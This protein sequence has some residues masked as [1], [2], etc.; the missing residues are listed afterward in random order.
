MNK[1]GFTMVELIAVISILGL[2][3]T[4]VATNGFGV[5]ETS[6]KRIKEDAIKEVAEGAKV[7]LTDVEY[8]DEEINNDVLNKFY[9]LGL[10]SA[11]SCNKLQEEVVGNIT[12]EGDCLEFELTTLK[13]LKYVTSD[14]VQDIIDED[15]D[16]KIRTCL[17]NKVKSIALICDEC[18]EDNF[19]TIPADIKLIQS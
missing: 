8:C 15:N 16:F 11:K 13:E 6:K 7:F 1:K 12:T 5:L 2:V 9:T 17:N 19:K 4:I 10:I 3:M 18:S 14:A